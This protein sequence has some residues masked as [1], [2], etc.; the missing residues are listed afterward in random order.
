MLTLLFASLLSIAVVNAAPAAKL[1]VDIPS[2]IGW[3]GAEF[4]ANVNITDVEDLHGFEFKL[5]WNTTYLDVAGVN[6]TSPEV[7]GANYVVY[8]NEKIENYNST[9]GRYW[10]NVSALA[11]APSFNGST[12]LVKLTFKATYQAYYP[13]P[14]AVV[15]L[16]LYD[17]KLSNQDG[18]PIAHEAYGDLYL[19]PT[20]GIWWPLSLSVAYA[21]WWGWANFNYEAKSL[22]EN[23]TTN[24]YIDRLAPGWQLTGWTAKLAY[25]T[26]LLDV[27]KV[28]EGPFLQQFRTADKRYFTAKMS[29]EQ[30]YVDM[31]GGI[32]GTGPTPWCSGILATITFNVTYEAW[33]STNATCVL[34][35]YDANMTSSVYSTMPFDAVD[36]GLYRAPSTKLLGDI[37]LDE[38]V[39]IYDLAYVGIRFGAEKGKP[40]LGVQPYEANADI[41]NDGIIDIIDIATIGIHFGDTDP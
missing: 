16:D 6:I 17:T 37:N 31:A 18:L 23:F 20:V 12:V 5:F 1:C 34:D 15:H 41:N 33:K 9:H 35:L 10:L 40:A 2:W 22:G 39:D 19:I 38:T 21:Y 26:T 3:L 14:D 36:D 32:L 8:K 29:E 30:G 4:V 13:E 27:L 7:W 11:P 24:L 28:E 25:N